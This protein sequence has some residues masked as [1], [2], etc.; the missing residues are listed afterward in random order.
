MLLCLQ[1]RSTQKNTSTL[2]FT[3]GVGQQLQWQKMRMNYY[4]VSFMNTVDVT[5]VV[6]VL[7]NFGIQIVLDLQ[8]Y[9]EYGKQLN[10]DLDVRNI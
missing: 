1:E 3:I 9:M 5:V 2:E 8:G 7:A 6:T 10:F 4:Q